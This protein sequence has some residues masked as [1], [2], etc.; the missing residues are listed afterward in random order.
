MVRI[1]FEMLILKTTVR[2]TGNNEIMYLILLSYCYFIFAVSG[3]LPFR[4]V[5]GYKNL[6]FDG[7]YGISRTKGTR[8]ACWL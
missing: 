6:H 7:R 3:L 2:R 8:M 5:V 4:L 1:S